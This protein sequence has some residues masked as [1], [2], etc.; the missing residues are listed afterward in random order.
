[1][2]QRRLLLSRGVCPVLGKR[3]AE[4]DEM[5][6]GA[7]DA[8]VQSGLICRGDTVVITAGI[9]PS[10]PGS[11]GSTDLMKVQTIP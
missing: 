6:D 1:M 4:T 5:L 7:I 2:V 3:A 9:S 11:P 10:M 8:A